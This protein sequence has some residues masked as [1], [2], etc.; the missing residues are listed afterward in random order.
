MLGDFRIFSCQ[1]SLELSLCVSRSVATPDVYLA[2]LMVVL[3]V[4]PYISHGV[5][6]RSFYMVSKR[7][8]S[9]L[10]DLFPFISRGV[11]T[12]KSQYGKF[13][14]EVLTWKICYLIYHAVIEQRA[15]TRDDISCWLDDPKIIILDQVFIA[16]SLPFLLRRFLVIRSSSP[17]ILSDHLKRKLTWVTWWELSAFILFWVYFLVHVYTLVSGVHTVFYKPC[18]WVYMVE[19]TL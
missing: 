6:T 15:G 4:F 18:W 11:R 12:R 5:R 8:L 19:W 9:W 1:I 16:G 14:C 17:S 3:I 13:V 10:K 7:V 2:S